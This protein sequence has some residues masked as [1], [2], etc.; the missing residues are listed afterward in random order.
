MEFVRW[1]NSLSIVLFLRKEVVTLWYSPCWNLFPAFTMTTRKAF[2]LVNPVSGYPAY[3]AFSFW[4]LTIYIVLHKIKSVVVTCLKRFTGFLFVFVKSLVCNFR[5]SMMYLLRWR[6]MQLGNILRYV[7]I[8]K[9]FIRLIN[10]C[11]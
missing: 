7:P 5:W 4:T 8:S 9:A 1:I 10:I 2:D 3:D 11:C 6:S